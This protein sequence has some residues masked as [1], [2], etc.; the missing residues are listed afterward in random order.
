MLGLESQVRRRHIFWWN[1]RDDSSSVRW[2]LV[3][4]VDVAAAVLT[5]VAMYLVVVVYAVVLGVQAQGEPDQTLIQR[6]AVVVGAWLG[7]VLGYS[8]PSVL[9][10]GSRGGQKPP[11]QH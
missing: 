6:F 5:F 11:R 10:L 4:L 7:T 1:E 9:R 8:S 3:L 2:G